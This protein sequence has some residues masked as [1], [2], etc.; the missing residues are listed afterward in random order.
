MRSTE[1]AYASALVVNY[2]GGQFFLG[3][4]A[5]AA[6]AFG[7]GILLGLPALRIKGLALALVTL[8]FAAV[9]PALLGMIDGVTNAPNNL[10]I[11][12]K[13]PNPRSFSDG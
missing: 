6:V 7:I 8:A 1:S 5:G 10:R 11:T 9:F 4:V 13:I 2:Y 3:I 12:Y